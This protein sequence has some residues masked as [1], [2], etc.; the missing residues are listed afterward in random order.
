VFSENSN[1]LPSELEIIEVCIEEKNCKRPL[2]DARFAVIAVLQK[3]CYSCDGYC[4]K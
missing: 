3:Y 1:E 4:G 2:C